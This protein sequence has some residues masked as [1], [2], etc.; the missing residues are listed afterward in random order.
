[1]GFWRILGTPAVHRRNFAVLAKLTQAIELTCFCLTVPQIACRNKI[2]KLLILLALKI[3]ESAVRFCPWAPIFQALRT[4]IRR[5]SRLHWRDSRRAVSPIVAP[6]NLAQPCLRISGPVAILFSNS[7]AYVRR[8]VKICIGH[9]AC[10]RAAILRPH[11][12]G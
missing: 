3:P 12:S 4:R 11:F 6:K 2:S 7:V 10:V 5:I 1:M 9:H 8:A